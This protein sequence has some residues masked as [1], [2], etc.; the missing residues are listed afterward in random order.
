MDEYIE[1]VKTVGR[2]K[3]LKAYGRHED[4]REKFQKRPD[5]TLTQREGPRPVIC[6]RQSFLFWLLYILCVGF[7]GACGA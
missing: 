3:R 2:E 5:G 6:A 1:C 7:T 4:L